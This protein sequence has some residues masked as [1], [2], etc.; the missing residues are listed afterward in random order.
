MER[1][2]G[3]PRTDAAF[4]AE[5]A[6]RPR[7]A[8]C[9]PAPSHGRPRPG[10]WPRPGRATSLRAAPRAWRPPSR[11]TP[12]PWAAPSRR[13]RTRCRLTVRGRWARGRWWWGGAGRT[14]RRPLPPPPAAPTPWPAPEDAPFSWRDRWYPVRLV[15]DLDEAA[16]NALTV[17]GTPVVV[18]RS[19]GAWAAARDECPHRLAPLSDG[20]LEHGVLSC[21]YHGCAGG[22]FFFFLVACARAA[23]PR[24]RPS[25][26]SQL[27]IQRVRRLHPVSASHRRGG[28]GGGDGVAPVAAAVFS[29]ARVRR[30]ALDLAVARPDGGRGGGRDAAAAVG[31]VRGRGP[32]LPRVGGAGKRRERGWACSRARRPA[33]QPRRPHPSPRSGA[34]CAPP[35]TGCS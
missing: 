18:W 31:R 23:G 2:E 7:V 9:A 16:P 11:P 27:G 33:T 10:A 24:S 5:P 19:G 1:S 13:S 21:R 20:R 30:P 3:R 32:G 29:G 4:T 22:E 8:R 15:A 35:S 6:A 25:T 12:R 28:G 17:L 14:W 34:S 26:L